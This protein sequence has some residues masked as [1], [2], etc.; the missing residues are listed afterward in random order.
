MEKKNKVLTGVA[1]GLLS[2]VGAYMGRDA[3]MRVA[4]PPPDAAEMV[5]LNDELEQTLIRP[6]QEDQ[7]AQPPTR[8]AFLNRFDV[9]L[10]NILDV[11]MEDIAVLIALA[12][13]EEKIQLVDEGEAFFG[14]VVPEEEGYKKVID[15]TKVRQ[16]LNTDFEALPEEEQPTQGEFVQHIKNTML[17]AL[18]EKL[19]EKKE[20]YP[21]MKAFLPEARKIVFS[22]KTSP[23]IEEMVDTAFPNMLNGFEVSQKAYAARIAA[24]EEAREKEASEKEDLG[25]YTQQEITKTDRGRGGR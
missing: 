3:L 2:T 20:E 18:E 17:K 15:L 12:A 24:R 9:V 11:Y 25:T 22:A 4:F 7:E 16:E 21:Y 6:L 5:A 14:Y 1:L 8:E 10:E 13:Q 23:R 19:A